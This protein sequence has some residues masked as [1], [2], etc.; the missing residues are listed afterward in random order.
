MFQHRIAEG[1]GE[2]MIGERQVVPQGLYEQVIATCS[3]GLVERTPPRID[4]G[5]DL[6][7]RQGQ[8]R[9]VAVAATHIEY[10]IG[11]WDVGVESRLNGAQQGPECR[12][13]FELLPEE[14]VSRSAG[15]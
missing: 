12:K 2:I 8:L 15:H 13:R 4:P 9:E 7:A 10:R 5:R 14:V 11:Q 1:A 6:P 3:G